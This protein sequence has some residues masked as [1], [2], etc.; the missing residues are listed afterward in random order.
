MDRWN[1]IAIRISVNCMS[2]GLGRAMTKS[3]V[4]EL[5]RLPFFILIVIHSSSPIIL[6]F[7]EIFFQEINGVSVHCSETYTIYA[8]PE[9]VEDDIEVDGG[10]YVV[11]IEVEDVDGDT[12]D[13]EVE[14]VMSA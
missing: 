7:D 6:H 8:V 10:E 2:P 3:F 11:E 1:E 4:P 13:V 12:E 9:G 5:N 14:D